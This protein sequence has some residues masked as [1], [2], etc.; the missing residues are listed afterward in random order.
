[1][2]RRPPTTLQLSH[3]DVSSLIDDLNEQKLKQQLNV[4]KTKYFQGKNTTSLRS[5]TDIQ[6][7]SQNVE[8]N[9]DDADM[10]SC[11]D[12]PASVAHNRIRNSLHLSADSNTTHETPNASDNPF[13]IREE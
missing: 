11:N 3:D 5:H 6:D 9:D 2:I 4:Q 10:S 13:Y 12:K 1:M 8:D 7:V